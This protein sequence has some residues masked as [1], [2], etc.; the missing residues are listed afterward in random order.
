MHGKLILLT[1]LMTLTLTSYAALAARH[2]VS[3]KI[4]SHRSHVAHVMASLR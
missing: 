2:A 1:I 4:E 3:V